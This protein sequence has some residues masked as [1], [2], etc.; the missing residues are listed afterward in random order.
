MS[1]LKFTTVPSKTLSESITAAASS[2]KLAD[3]TGWDSEDL[4]AGDFGDPV[5]VVF[6]NSTNTLI[7][8]MEIDPATIADASIT[9]SKR[10]LQYDGNL[11]TEVA[12][13][14]LT[15]TKGDT[16]VDLGS[17]TPQLFQWL[18]EYIDAA[19][20]AGA[21]PAA[22]ATAGIVKIATTTEL[23]AATEDDGTY[24]YVPNAKELDDSKYGQQL[25]TSDE[26]DALAGGGDFGTPATG[27]KYVTENYTD[28][29]QKWDVYTANDTWTKPTNARFV[30]VIAIGGGG[31]GEGGGSVAASNDR[32]GGGG[33]GAGGYSVMNFAVGSLGAT[34]TVTVGAGGAGGAGATGAAGAGSAGTAGGDTSFGTLVVAKGGSNGSGGGTAGSGGAGMTEDGGAGGAGTSGAA[35]TAAASSSGIAPTGGGGGGGANNYDGAAGGSKT[36]V[37]LSGGTG[38]A[39]SAPGGGDAGDAGATLGSNIAHGGTGGGGGEGN[40]DSGAAGAGGA[41]G[42]YGAGGGGGGSTNDSLTAGAGGAGADGIVVV[43]SY[44]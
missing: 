39:G 4:A 6:R 25:P 43:I 34:E 31:G 40:S 13:N 3:I 38:G 19:S 18:K 36:A 7:E 1:V 12:A 5:Y 10:G 9:I 27:N 20:I 24:D 29:A 35:G 26:K 15:W 41:G 21:V 42:N 17:D 28:A 32:A 14:K 30:K 2:F 22:N 33:G 16:F 8:L 11:T 37:S 23:N 44:L